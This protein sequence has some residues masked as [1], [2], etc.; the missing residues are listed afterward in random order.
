M[1]ISHYKEKRKYT[2]H[3]NKNLEIWT[4]LLQLE[5]KVHLIMSVVS[6]F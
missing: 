1:L 4:K 5:N 3:E 6:S 2:V